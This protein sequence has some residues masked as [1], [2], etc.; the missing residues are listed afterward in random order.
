MLPCTEKVLD[1]VQHRALRFDTALP[2]ARSPVRVVV[3][4]HRN[5]N[6]LPTKIGAA[7]RLIRERLVQ[8]ATVK[9]NSISVVTPAGK[10]LESPLKS[11][12]RMREKTETRPEPVLLAVW[13]PKGASG[14][15]RRSEVRVMMVS[16][17]E[18]RKA[19]STMIAV[20][21]RRREACTKRAAKKSKKVGGQSVP[22][23]C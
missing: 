4:T 5:T 2:Q 14:R 3:W 17:D 22:G 18:R 8:R 12:P 9:P 10:I 11:L 1:L 21:H 7:A 20:S 19:T 13:R 23:S 15:K 6:S 16:G